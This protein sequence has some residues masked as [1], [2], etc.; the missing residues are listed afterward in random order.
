[1][2]ESKSLEEKYEALKKEYQQHL[3]HENIRSEFDTLLI[4]SYQKGMKSVTHE[5]LNKICEVFNAY[6]GVMYIHNHRL[7]ILR[8]SA[9]YACIKKNLQHT[10]IEIGQ[11]MI[12]QAAKQL[13]YR[14]FEN[15]VDQHNGS[16]SFSLNKANILILPLAFDQSCFGVMELIF[17]K[18]ISSDQLRLL[19]TIAKDLAII[20]E[21]VT[22]SERIKRKLALSTKLEEEVH[23]SQT[24]LLKELEDLRIENESLR[25]ELDNTKI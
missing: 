2:D 24:A 8:A 4:S 7:N 5:S 15:I 10:R 20:M 12:G 25:K 13:K 16:S 11:G 21:A 6:R 14:Y 17:T 23:Q 18:K 19:L 1:M 3:K 22:A 9:T